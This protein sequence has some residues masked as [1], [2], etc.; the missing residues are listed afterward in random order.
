MIKKEIF[1]LLIIIWSGLLI[2]CEGLKYAYQHIT[3]AGNPLKRYKFRN[4]TIFPLGFDVSMDNKVYF[5]YRNTKGNT[6]CKMDIDTGLIYQ[7]TE[8]GNFDFNP[9]VSNNG[10]I[11]LFQRGNLFGKTSYYLVDSDGKNCRKLLDTDIYLCDAVFSANDS[12]I[13]FIGGAIYNDTTITAKFYK[14]CQDIFSIDIYG[15]DFQRITYNCI[16]SWIDDLFLSKDGKYLILSI[17]GEEWESPVNKRIKERLKITREPFKGGIYK[18]SI[19]DFALN[20]IEL[21][22]DT[23]FI[24]DLLKSYMTDTP[25]NFCIHPEKDYSLV[26]SAYGI[27][28]LDIEKKTVTTC[29]DSV[30]NIPFS[31]LDE[32]LRIYNTKFLS[33][34]KKL[35]GGIGD[36]HNFRLVLFDIETKTIERELPV[37]ST[38]FVPYQAL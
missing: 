16:T 32:S 23:K 17:S 10:K 19:I 3:T 29:I 7:L 11:I 5:P 1:Q 13:Y 6:I 30:N 9:K 38:K 4:D 21:E 33:N 22:I 26:Y 18:L 15:K 37:D 24:S 36:T 20:R 25:S 31:K 28:K 27:F 8:D 12:H 34:G 2:S 35:V 14:N